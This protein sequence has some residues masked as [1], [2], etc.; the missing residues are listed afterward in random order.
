LAAV[1]SV[2]SALLQANEVA[3]KLA[4]FS[5][6]YVV[7]SPFRRC[8]QTSAGVVK[9]LGLQQG[10]WLVDWQLSEVGGMI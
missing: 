6:D 8:L 4:G 7:S 2:S 3:S 9:Q 1:S 10:Q 5:V